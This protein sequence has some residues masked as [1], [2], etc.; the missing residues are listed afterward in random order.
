M[1]KVSSSRRAAG[2][3]PTDYDHEISLVDHDAARTPPETITPEPVNITRSSTT[4]RLLP[5]NR[6]D[7]QRTPTPTQED[8]QTEVGRDTVGDQA[9]ENEEEVHPPMVRP[10]IEVQ[11]KLS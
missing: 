2:L 8:G 10:S 9:R 1:L 5:P 4:S 11:G 3:R 7:Q 6:D